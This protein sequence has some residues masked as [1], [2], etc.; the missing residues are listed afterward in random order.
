MNVEL[1]MA[2]KELLRSLKNGAIAHS[3][4][5]KLISIAPRPKLNSACQF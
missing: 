5:C 2:G 3:F 1:F 4:R